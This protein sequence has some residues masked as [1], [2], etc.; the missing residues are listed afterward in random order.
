M[1]LAT[2][3]HLT[4][5][6]QACIDTCY[7]AVQACEWCAD[8]C[9]GEGEE[10]VTCLRLCRDVTGVASLLIQYIARDSNYTPE[11]AEVCA[12]TAE[13]CAEECERHDAEHCQVCADVLREC[14]E[15][16]RD[17]MSTQP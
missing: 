11:L 2:L 7:E 6:Q 1:A 14:A 5:E 12:G 3:E 8:E 10:M 17:M 16:C 9:A 13:Q 15:S 4:D